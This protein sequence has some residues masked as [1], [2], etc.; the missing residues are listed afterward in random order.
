MAFDTWHMNQSQDERRHSADQAHHPEHPEP[1][2]LS[3]EVT[4]NRA[5]NQPSVDPQDLP[6]EAINAKTN[7]LLNEQGPA[8]F[9]QP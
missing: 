9:R 3:V 5:V 7:A 8:Q 6:L 4:R 1:R 2:N